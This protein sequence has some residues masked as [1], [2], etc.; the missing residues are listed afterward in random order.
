LSSVSSF[1]QACEEYSKQNFQKS[2]S[3]FDKSLETLKQDSVM[4][5]ERDM[6]FI[7][8]E[9]YEEALIYLDKILIINTNDIEILIRKGKSCEILGKT[10][11]AIECFNQILSIQPSNVDALRGMAIIFI[12]QEKYEDAMVNLDQILLT[13][14]NDFETI[15]FKG[16]VLEQLGQLA[17]AVNYY[18]KSLKITSNDTDVLQSVSLHMVHL[19]GK[20]HAVP[21]FKSLI[22]NDPNDILAQNGL[23]IFSTNPIY[24]Y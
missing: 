20:E 23:K 22:E 4:L 5:Q 14:P 16:I 18:L 1:Q 11:Q 8:L 3:L 9:K 21:I 15:Y 24:D 19:L 17:Q 12:N 7:N 6:I 2:Y 13:D 10:E